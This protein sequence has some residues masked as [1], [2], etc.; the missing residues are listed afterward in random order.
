MRKT[1]VFHER[2][3]NPELANDK[4]TRRLHHMEDGIQLGIFGADEDCESFTFGGRRTNWKT[5]KGARKQDEIACARRFCASTH[6]ELTQLTEQ[7]EN[8]AIDV[9]AEST[10]KKSILKLQITSAWPPAFWE[11]LAGGTV[12]TRFSREA[13]VDLMSAAIT[14]K[15]KKKPSS[16]DVILLLDTY[17]VGIDA[18]CLSVFRADQDLF[19]DMAREPKIFEEIWLVDQNG[20]VR[21]S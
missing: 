12:D 11:S 1:A 4:M 20:S 5:N 13:L 7:P 9:L 14:N 15:K 8:S 17:P 6:P 10:D 21:I 3:R 2:V 16:R 18:R 19:Q